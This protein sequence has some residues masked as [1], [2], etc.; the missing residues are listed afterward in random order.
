MDRF[1]CFINLIVVV[2]LVVVGFGVDINDSGLLFG[3]VVF[4][5]GNWLM[6]VCVVCRFGFLLLW[7]RVFIVCFIVVI[8]VD[9]LVR[10]CDNVGVI[11]L[12]WYCLV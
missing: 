1:V 2:F 6:M 12:V 9:G 4:Y 11:R 5:F 7:L 3:W 8:C 10:I